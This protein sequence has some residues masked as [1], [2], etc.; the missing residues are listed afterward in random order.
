MWQRGKKEETLGWWE[1]ED[2]FIIE[3]DYLNCNCLAIYD[4]F[5]WLKS[6]PCNF[7][8]YPKIKLFIPSSIPY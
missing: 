7:M 8:I 1:G 5:L 3:V 4:G 6:P 2:N